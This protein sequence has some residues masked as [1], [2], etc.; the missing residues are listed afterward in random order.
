MVPSRPNTLPASVAEFSDL[1]GKSL[2]AA[3]DGKIDV[4]ISKRDLIEALKSCASIEAERRGITIEHVD[5]ALEAR[6]P[7]SI[8]AIVDLRVRKA[9]F[10]AKIKIGGTLEIDDQ[11]VA[12]VSDL[13]CHGNGV[14]GALACASL[15]PFLE[16]ANDRSF[17]LMTQPMGEVQLHDVQMTTTGDQISL[18]A[19]F[20]S[21]AA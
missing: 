7:Q 18:R 14:I 11:L 21:G 9:F 17:P 15:R 19:R 3:V 1:L 20:G 8:A 6:G 5:L 4:S 10:S 2:R 12:N 16:R 13:S